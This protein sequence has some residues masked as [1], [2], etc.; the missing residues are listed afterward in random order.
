MTIQC[1]V[2]GTENLDGEQICQRCGIALVR[3]GIS[4]V[5]DFEIRLQGDDRAVI[6]LEAPQNEGYVLGRS[7]DG[8][9]YKPD[10]DFARFGA[11]ERGVSRRHA[12]L[13]RF[14]G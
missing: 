14:Q 8:S 13:V 5:N 9:D 2:C 6:Q 12:A 11:R 1:K 3:S 4:L 7:E 10:I